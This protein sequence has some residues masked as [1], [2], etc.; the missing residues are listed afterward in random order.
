MNFTWN[1]RLKNTV[2]PII[3]VRFTFYLYTPPLWPRLSPGSP[4]CFLARVCARERRKENENIIARSACAS[5][6]NASIAAVLSLSL[7]FSLCLW[8]FPSVSLS[9]LAAASRR[10]Y[11][12]RYPQCSS[13]KQR[14]SNRALSCVRVIR[15]LSLQFLSPVLLNVL[16]LWAISRI[17]SE[18]QEYRERIMFSG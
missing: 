7:S 17:R 12:Q 6:I 2:Y 15:I 4:A 3:P 1:L 10:L 9:P 14:I 11:K 5:C 8:L 18:I 16:A 13:Y